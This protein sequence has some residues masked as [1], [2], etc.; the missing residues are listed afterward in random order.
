MREKTVKS[1]VLWIIALIIIE[2]VSS[3]G[4][5]VINNKIVQTILESILFLLVWGIIIATI[6]LIGKHNFNKSLNLLPYGFNY[7]AEFIVYKNIG[8]AKKEKATKILNL[9]FQIPNVYTEWKTQLMDSYHKINNNENFY[10]YL[11]KRLRSAKTMCEISTSVLVPIEIALMTVT[12]TSFG[13]N[14]E[15]LVG[16]I[17]SAIMLG[18]MLTYELCKANEERDFILD[19]INILCSDFVDNE[20]E[21][22]R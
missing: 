3:I 4:M 1:N 11:K 19:V 8:K 20:K 22:N 14:V 21:Y 15:K 13:E 16:I 5:V 17:V 12:I 10:H 6:D 9:E 2:V 7:N 18:S